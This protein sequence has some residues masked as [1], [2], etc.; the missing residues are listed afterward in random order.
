MPQIGP[1]QDNNKSRCKRCIRIKTEDNIFFRLCWNYKF[2]NDPLHCALIINCNKLE[3][4]M[5]IRI[6]VSTIESV[7]YITYKTSVTLNCNHV[8][9]S[10]FKNL[11][12][13]CR[14]KLQYLTVVDFQW[15]VT[16]KLRTWDDHYRTLKNRLFRR[17]V[18][19]VTLS[20]D[21]LL[22]VTATEEGGPG[23]T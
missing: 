17:L 6:V 8:C 21:N 22:T 3:I 20:S 12:V 11:V 18:L 7:F 10:T 4:I 19:H 23:Q 16:I 15:A 1:R 5:Y 2:N 13:P 9:D 14:M